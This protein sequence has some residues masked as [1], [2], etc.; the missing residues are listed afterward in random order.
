LHG[1]EEQGVSPA[2]QA[3]MA[4]S[5]LRGIG[6][7][8]GFAKLVVFCGHGSQTANNPLQ[9]G[10]DC[11]ACG[12][13][14][15]EAN[16]RFAAKLLNQQHVRQALVER[17]IAIGDDVRFVGALH[18]TTTDELEFFD[19]DQLPASHLNDLDELT[20][21]AKIASRSNRAERLDVLPGADET[22]LVR[23]SLDWSEVR[24][25]WG[26]AGNAAFI[27]APR[28][29]TEKVSL[30]GRS[31]LH[32]YNYKNDPEF[33]VLEQIMTAPM[34]VANWINLQYYASTVD[35]KHFGSGNKAIHNVVGR[36]GV[37]S[38][39]GGDLMTGL[40]WQSVHDGETLQHHPLRLMVV[41]AA[42]RTAIDRVISKHDSIND[43]L[44][45]GWI[46]LVALD[47]DGYYRWSESQ[48]WERISVE[49]AQQIA[50]EAVTSL[51]PCC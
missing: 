3:E 41:L 47:D 35:P 38:G 48:S 5:I 2:K 33:K 23:R 40:P 31:F 20:Q 10:L 24:P 11:G 16:A 1:L 43:L 21:Y 29:L 8:E 14:S 28:G 18:N 4:E 50:D 6:I 51:C 12:G 46:Q 34:V 13:H 17:G 15:G 22:D 36:F 44:S 27:A 26:L 42:P 9:A 25:E 7:V 37:L 49:S 30:G 45:N 19:V 39:N 32:S